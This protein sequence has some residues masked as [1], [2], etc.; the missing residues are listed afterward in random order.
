MKEKSKRSKLE[1]FL[2]IDIKNIIKDDARLI[3][4]DLRD[5]LAK[6]NYYYYIKDNP[7]ISDHQYDMLLRNLSMIEKRNYTFCYFWS[8]LLY[9]FNF[10]VSCM[11][12]T[13]KVRKHSCKHNRSMGADISDSH[14]KKKP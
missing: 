4:E 9:F 8:N 6:H 10:L 11:H 1:E 7:I 14:C 3:V 5:E 12:Q 13:V 2:N